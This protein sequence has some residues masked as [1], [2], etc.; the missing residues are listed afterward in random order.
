MN[1]LSLFSSN[2]RATTLDLPDGDVVLYSSWVDAPL[3]DRWQADLRTEIAWEEEHLQMFGKTVRSPRLIAWHGE[4]D[5][6]YQYSGLRHQPKQWTPTLIEIRDYLERAVGL[7]FNSVLV[8]LYRG[9]D[10]S[11][12]YHADNEPELG[13]QPTI[14]SLSLGA[15]RRF[16]LRHTRSGKRISIDLAHGDLLVMGGALQSHWKHALPKTRRVVNE[17]IN[18]TWRRIIDPQ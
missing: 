2:S 9:G 17:R 4:P 15:T 11:M 13:F 14:A 16:L 12:G 10:D 6:V 8:N 3:A 7:S 18:L 1:Q 5:A